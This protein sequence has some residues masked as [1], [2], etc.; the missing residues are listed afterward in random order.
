M[1]REWRISHRMKK[2]LMLSQF[3]KNDKQLKENYRLI[4]LLP[5]CG[6]ILERLIYNKM[7]KFFIDDELIYFNQSGFKPGDSCINQSSCVHTMFINLLMTTLRQELS[8]S[9]YQKHL[10]KFG[11]RVYSK[12]EAKWYI[13]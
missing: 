5:I 11:I 12:T 7:F 13:R 4:A 9:T 1:H 8:F 10:I 6:K 2:K 3:I